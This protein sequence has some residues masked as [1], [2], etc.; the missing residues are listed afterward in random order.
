MPQLKNVVLVHGAWADGSS[1]AKLIPR[2][3]AEGLH[4]TAVQ[5]PL[6]SLADD[7]ATVKRALDREDG[8]LVLVGHSYGGA[9]ISEAGDHPKG[10]ALVYVAAFAPGAG[11]SLASLIASAA[12]SPLGDEVRP[13]ANGF[14]KITPK[15]I[16]EDFAQDL[17]E[18]E[19][20]L[21]LAAQGPL[22]AKSFE[23][24]NTA[25][26][27]RKKPSFYLIAARDRAIN[28]ELQKAMAKKI[29]AETITVVSSH[30]PMLSQ[31][32]QVARFIKRAA[33]A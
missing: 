7:A 30:V 15:G 5:L 11:E 12:P 29:N 20:R 25:E 28:P 32:D 21:L 23:S 13:D 22:F 31:P 18:P 33:G 8:P 19:Q 2:L 6:T 4:V 17:T 14:L 24:R 1:W 9:V 10:T 16:A 27:W 3:E 26:A